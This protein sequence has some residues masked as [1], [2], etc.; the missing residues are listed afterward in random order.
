MIL[1]MVKET[2]EEKEALRKECE[3]W[4]LTEEETNEVLSGKF[5]PWNTDEPSYF[6]ENGEVRDIYRTNNN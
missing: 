5:E 3:E 6:D 4:G 1:Q 2:E